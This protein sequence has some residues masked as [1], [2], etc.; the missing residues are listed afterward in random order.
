MSAPAFAKGVRF[1]R[2]PDGQG[3]LLIPEGVVNFNA[4]AAAIVE[5]I[6][7]ERTPTDIARE[8]SARY[9]AAEADLVRD[10]E[11]LLND[12]TSRTWLVLSE[13]GRR[14]ATASEQW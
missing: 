13:A 1:R 14:E 8:L 12:L 2:M 5:L 4:S 6:D 3:M 10:V 9:G 11:T 7:G